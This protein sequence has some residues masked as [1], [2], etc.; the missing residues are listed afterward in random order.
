MISISVMGLGV[1]RGVAPARFAAHLAAKLICPLTLLIWFLLCPI[2][3]SADTL[4]APGQK[5]SNKGGRSMSAIDID[6]DGDIDIVSNYDGTYTYHEIFLLENNG[7]TEPIFIKHTID[8]GLPIEPPW[9]ALCSRLCTTIPL[10]F[11][12]ELG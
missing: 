11:S 2:G 6:R 7:A 8:Q 9:S 10:R 5:I 4:F 1:C 3:S 12:N